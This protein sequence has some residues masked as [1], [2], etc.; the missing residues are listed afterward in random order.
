[1]MFVL[2]L[3]LYC[4]FSGGIVLRVLVVFTFVCLCVFVLLFVCLC[5]LCVFV[6][7]FVVWFVCLFFFGVDVYVCDL[8]V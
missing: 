7:L 6:G 5:I 1:M 2:L 3:F 8:L 4:F